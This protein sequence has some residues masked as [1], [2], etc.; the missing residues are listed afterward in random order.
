MSCPSP[1]AIFYLIDEDND[2]LTDEEEPQYSTGNKRKHFDHSNGDRSLTSKRTRT[3]FHSDSTEF[4]VLDS[5]DSNDEQ[6]RSENFDSFDWTQE[7]RDHSIDF[8][9]P[10][11]ES[12]KS[13]WSSI[14]EPVGHFQTIPNL[15]RNF[16]S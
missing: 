5:D 7:I 12:R 8:P 15:Q 14:F 1:S 10:S 4:I 3:D 13:L 6:Q 2:S 11:V 9:S 16:V